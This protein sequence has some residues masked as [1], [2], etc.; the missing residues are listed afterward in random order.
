MVGRIAYAPALDGD[1]KPITDYILVGKLS[2]DMTYV[3]EFWVNPD[4]VTKVEAPRDQLATVKWFMSD[5]MI[6][7]DTGMV[8]QCLSDMWSTWE[9]FLA[10]HLR[11]V[12]STE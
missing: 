12:S 10:Y 3:S 11:G 8:R 6:K 5:D 1:I 9:N 7:Q 2:S 4:H